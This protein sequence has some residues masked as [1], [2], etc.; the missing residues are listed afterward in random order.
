MNV[1]DSNFARGDLLLAKMMSYVDMLCAHVKVL[2]VCERN[3]GLVVDMDRSSGGRRE[4]KFSEQT[5]KP[6]SLTSSVSQSHIFRFYTGQSG[7]GL[8][9]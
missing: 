9:L 8:F 5:T 1:V 7:S 4:M 2:I 3:C 6:D